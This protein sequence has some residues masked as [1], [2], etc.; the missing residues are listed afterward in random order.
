MLWMCSDPLCHS[1]KVRTFCDILHRRLASFLWVLL[2]LNLYFFLFLLMLSRGKSNFSC[3]WHSKLVPNADFFFPTQ[4]K[5]WVFSESISFRN[6][7]Y[8]MLPNRNSHCPSSHL[9]KNPRSSESLTW[10][11]EVSYIFKYLWSGVLPC[12]S[13]TVYLCSV[14][15]NLFLWKFR[16]WLFI[17]NHETLGHKQNTTINKSCAN[18]K[19]TYKS[20]KVYNYS[21]KSNKYTI[22]L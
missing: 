5:L 17:T 13:I 6:F 2:L 14:S 9:K 22:L 18:S 10:L 19:V 4:L 20:S 3:N 7:A 21:N 15:W 11:Y 16:K 12:Y 8:N 1:V